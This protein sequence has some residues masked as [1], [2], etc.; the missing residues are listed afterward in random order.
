[1]SRIGVQTGLWTTMVS[2]G[3]SGVFTNA[4]LAK[5]TQIDP[6]LL[7][8]LH[9]PPLNYRDHHTYMLTLMPSRAST[10]LLSVP[11]HGFPD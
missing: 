10:S 3:A 5:Q 1:M 4:E 8:K 2:E 9:P 6:V 7:S 11:K